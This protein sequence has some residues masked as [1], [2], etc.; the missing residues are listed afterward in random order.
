MFKKSCRA[1]P[2]ER[3]S[4][5]PQNMLAANILESS[6]AEKDLGVPVDTKLSMSQQHTLAARKANSLLGC[7]G[8]TIAS[9]LR[10]V[11]LPLYSALMR[12]IWSAG[13]S[14]GLPSTRETW[15]YWKESNEGHKDD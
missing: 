15:A 4:P 13:S 8:N 9:R 6:V 12:H 1:L 11:I 3:N 10:E 5:T 2:L 14:S 7:I